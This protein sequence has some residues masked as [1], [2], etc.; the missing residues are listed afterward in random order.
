MHF[1]SFACNANAPKKDLLHLISLDI[2]Q[3]QTLYMNPKG[4]AVSV[5]KIA[6]GAIKGYTPQ[7]ID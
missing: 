5:L 4:G 6:A 3:K 1:T 2:G 7:K